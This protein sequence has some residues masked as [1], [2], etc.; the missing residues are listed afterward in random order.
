MQIKSNTTT[1]K[2]SFTVQGTRLLEAI[3]N[4]DLALGTSTEPIQIDSF[5]TISDPDLY[6][7]T[8]GEEISFQLVKSTTPVYEDL[9]LDIV[10]CRMYNISK[11]F[12]ALIVTIP[13]PWVDVFDI[14][15]K[16]VLELPDGSLTIAPVGNKCPITV[17]ENIDGGTFTTYVLYNVIF[18]STIN[19]MELTGETESRTFYFAIDP[20]IKVTSG[21]SGG[22]L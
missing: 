2:I 13:R 1:K 4:T 16:N 17:A 3:K 6:E 21:G 7:F 18:K 14:S 20:L 11:E 5:V 22:K 12:N 9:D 10:A 15:P 19:V 8:S